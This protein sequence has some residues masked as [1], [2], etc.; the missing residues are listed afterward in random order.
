[1]VSSAKECRGNVTVIGQ[2]S[3]IKSGTL[4]SLYAGSHRSRFRCARL[5][6]DPCMPYIRKTGL[7]LREHEGEEGV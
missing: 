5:L 2:K 7:D 6:L 3:K 4:E 1:M